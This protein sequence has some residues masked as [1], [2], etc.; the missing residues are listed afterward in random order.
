METELDWNLPEF[1]GKCLG[2]R[3]YPRSSEDPH[4]CF[5][6]LT[7]DEGNWLLGLNGP[8]SFWLPDLI[9]ALSKAR[10]WMNKNCIKEQAEDGTTCGYKF[11]PEW[12]AAVSSASA[13]HK[14]EEWVTTIQQTWTDQ[15]DDEI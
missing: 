8:S 5:E 12:M 10:T 11:S 14:A 15:D 3:L 1:K 2:V 13:K 4:V 6:L 9:T 7:E